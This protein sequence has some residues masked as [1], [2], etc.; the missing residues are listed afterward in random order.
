MRPRESKKQ[1]NESF[2][3][4]GKSGTAFSAKGAM[5]RLAWGA[6]PGLSSPRR[7][8]LKAR[9]IFRQRSAGESRLQRFSFNFQQSW[10]AAPG[11]T[12]N[13]APSALTPA[14]LTKAAPDQQSEISNTTNMKSTEL[15]ADF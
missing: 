8:A 12:L 2:T 5:S 10:G 7:Q 14:E 13:G 9:F 3:R 6:A 1:T 11:S 4:E 15:T